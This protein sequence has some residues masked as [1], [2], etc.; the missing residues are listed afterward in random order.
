MEKKFVK[1]TGLIVSGI[2]VVLSFG[3][4][5]NVQPVVFGNPFDLFFD[6]ENENFGSCEIE[7]FS[8]YEEFIDFLKDNNYNKNCSSSHYWNVDGLKAPRT[9]DVMLANA[10]KSA[11]AGQSDSSSD[12]DFSETNIQV[13]GVDE[14]DIVK[15]DGTYIYLL[16]N[17]KIYIVKSYPEN[18]SKVLSTIDLDDI[19][20]SNLFLKNDKLIVFGSQPQYHICYGYYRGRYESDTDV[21]IYDISD[22]N[23]PEID[24]EIKID[25]SFIDARLIGNNIYIITSENTYNIYREIDGNETISIPEISINNVSKKI[26][27]E[28]IHYVNSSQKI[29]SLTYIVA[30]DLETNE[31]NQESFMFSSSSTLYVSKNNIY[32]TYSSYEYLEPDISRGRI[33]GYSSTK[34]II[35]KISINDNNIEY[36]SK[37]EVP[38]SII[39]QFS[40]DEHN[41]FFRIATQTN[42]YSK[43]KC[44]NVFVLNDTLKVVGK[45]T[46]IAPN[47]NMHS[48]R[49]MGNRAYLVTFLNIDP[50]FV[51]DLSDPYNPEILGELKIPGYSD[52]LHPYDENYVIGIG[53][54]SDA[55]ID[56]DKIHSDN[57][58]FYTA[59]L[60]VKIALFDVTDPE[61]PKEVSKV[62]IGD[63]G[64]NT[65]VLH[66]HKALL[67][68]REKE[69]FVIP[70][71]EVERDEDTD[72]IV[73]SFQGAYVYN[74]NS[75]D[76]FEYRGKIS[77]EDNEKSS[78]RY[79][80][81]DY[82]SSFSQIKRSL[83]IED[84]LYTISDSM[85]KMNDLRDLD[86]LNTIALS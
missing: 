48:A 36:I 31:V 37:G 61:N 42:D 67:F 15:T 24:Q 65:P 75:K 78:N 28:S 81:Y 66:N 19:Y 57:A 5:L 77:H 83:F 53:K 18:G 74:L 26:P 38:G 49:F 2:I 64:S 73:D 9:V 79:R 17:S 6:N 71:S 54:D 47:E 82:Y 33:Y 3:Y 21:N 63:R 58:V 11:S 70:V 84:T 7:T 35:H 27:V 25:G 68:D 62:V 60:G 4:A 69:L 51:I 72:D 39:N 13:E 41:G 55:S 1:L 10:E 56:S 52:Y 29:D 22:R 46:D 86:E 30:V 44:S 16:S 23:N 8:S 45:I 12:V 14:P 20:V 50:F 59:I 34:T 32:L 85:I 40:M 80:Y 76:G 43:D